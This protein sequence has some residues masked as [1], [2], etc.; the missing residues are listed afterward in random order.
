MNSNRR[1]AVVAHRHD[2]FQLVLVTILQAELGFSKVAIAMS[3]EDVVTSPGRFGR[4]EP[5]PLDLR[6]LASARS[7]LLMLRE[8]LP[9]R[10]PRRGRPMQRA[11]V[12]EALTAGVHGYISSEIIFRISAAPCPWS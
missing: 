1:I 6:M 11:N 7:R 12:L 8:V 10:P 2:L 9:E 5:R 4:Y 3:P